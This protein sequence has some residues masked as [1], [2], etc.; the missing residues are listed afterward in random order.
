MLY[1]CLSVIDAA[2][3]DDD[4]RVRFDA[5]NRLLIHLCRT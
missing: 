3:Y 1:D 5:A 4:G 2:L